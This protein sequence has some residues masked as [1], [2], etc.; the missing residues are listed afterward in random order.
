MNEVEFTVMDVDWVD[1]SAKQSEWMQKWDT[2]IKDTGK[3][4]K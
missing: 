1:L 4:V 2:E 3:D